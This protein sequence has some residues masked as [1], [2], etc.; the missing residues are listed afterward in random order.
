MKSKQRASVFPSDME[1]P[2]NLCELNK[3]QKDFI[4][5]FLDDIKGNDT[6][7]KK[8]LKKL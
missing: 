3:K 8:I 6:A 2:D 1:P 7:K 4:K 5:N